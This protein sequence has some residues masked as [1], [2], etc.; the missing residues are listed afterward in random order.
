M[1]TTMDH[2]QIKCTQGLAFSEL[3]IR[4]IAYDEWE[5]SLSLSLKTLLV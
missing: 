5:D 1:Q 2:F 3:G 4:G